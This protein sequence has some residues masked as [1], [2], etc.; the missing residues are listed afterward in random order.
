MLTK[1][2]S[3]YVS[4][5]PAGA[6]PLDAPRSRDAPPAFKHFFLAR[7]PPLSS[8]LSSK[9]SIGTSVHRLPSWLMSSVFRNL[10]P[11]MNVLRND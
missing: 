9:C 6:R 4:A 5:R 3:G 11:V 1:K 8:L 2:I 10:T 7:R